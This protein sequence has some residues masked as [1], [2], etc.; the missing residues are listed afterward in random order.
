MTIAVALG[1][2]AL[3]GDQAGSGDR[4]SVRI[5]TPAAGSTHRRAIPWSATAN[6]P[7]GIERV[8]FYVDGV[9]KFTERNAPYAPEQENVL[10][11]GEHALKVIARSRGGGRAE[12]SLKV[13]VAPGA[14]SSRRSPAP[15]SQPGAT[16]VGDFETGNLSRWTLIQRA[17][18]DRIR[19][20]TATDSGARPRQGSYMGRFEVRD[21][22]TGDSCDERSEVTWG[23]AD[24]LHF[25]AGTEDYI[26]FSTRWEGNFVCPPADRHS[27]FLQPKAGEGSPTFSLENR[28]CETRLRDEGDHTVAP[29]TRDVW[30]DFVVHVRWST[31]P[32]VGFIRIYHKLAGDP[33]YARRID[34]RSHTLNENG[35]AYLKLGYYRDPDVTGTSVIYHDG[36]RVGKSFRSV[37]PS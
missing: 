4:V 13:T 25:E 9:L 15:G 22:C 6:S 10:P 36:L 14:A 17:A 2:G 8:D 29:L 23:E 19:A 30:H 34:R 27:L 20:V 5:D 11:P 21:E 32:A 37:A 28:G 1:L 7:D 16:F 3:S 35:A 33:T 18:S 31:D 24:D 26:G 12:A